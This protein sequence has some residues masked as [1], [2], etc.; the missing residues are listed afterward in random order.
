MTVRNC[1]DNGLAAGEI[2][3]DEHAGLVQLYEGLL[4]HYGDPNAARAE[5]VNRLMAQHQHAQRQALINQDVLQRI[6]GFM[7]GYRNARGEADPAKAAVSLLNH[8]GRVR[9]PHGMSSVVGRYKSIV[10]LM[11]A[12][13]EALVDE[14]R[15]EW[16]TGRTGS[17]ARLENVVREAAG[18]GTGD[19]AAAFL[20][21]AWLR[22]AEQ[23][24]QRYNAAGGAI[25]ELQGWFLPQVHD[26]LSLLRAGMDQW[27]ADITP[28]IDLARMRHPLTGQPMTQADLRTSL[29]WVYRNITTDGWAEREPSAARR[30]LGAIANQ[31]QEH[32]FLHFRSADDW[33]DYH[34]QYGGG[35]DPWAAMMSHVKGMAEDIAAM[36]V[37]GTNP[38]ATIE[39]VEQF[40][41]RQ[42]ALRRA[43]QQAVFPTRS[44]YLGIAYEPDRGWLGARNPEDYAR[45]QMRR[46]R[47]MWDIYR[48]A[49]NAAVNQSVADAF[50]AMRNWNTATKLGGATLSALS[51]NAFQIV[52]R[53]FNG[54][55]AARAIPEIVGAFSRGTQ[56][57]AI[58]G[59]IILDT[60]TNMLRRDASWATTMQGPGWSRLLADRVIAYSG[61]QAVTQAGKHMFG[62]SWQ[63]EL[64]SRVAQTFAELPG[65]LRRA[66]EHYGLSSADWDAMRGSMA[67]N[68]FLRPPDVARAMQAAGRDGERI[69]E[70]YLEMILQ[71]TAYSTPEATL[72]ISA[73][74]YGGLR[75]GTFRDE[76]YRSIS[77][78]KMFGLTVAMLHSQ[79][80]A[81]QM[82]EEG[83]I[84]GAGYAASLLILTGVLGAMSLQLKRVA[85]GKD[86]RPMDVNM[87]ADSAK[88]WAAALLQGGGL[89]IYG[90]LLAA[91]QSRLGGGLART[92]AGPTL[93]TAASVLSLSS[94]NVGQLI[95]GDKTNVG[96]ELTRFVSGNTP[97]GTLWYVRAAY[98]HTLIDRL[99]RLAD[100]EAAAAFQRRMET[101]RRDY[102]SGFWWRPGDRLPD[103]APE[104]GL[105]LG[106]R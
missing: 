56:R 104:W 57:E 72:E 97:G 64:G 61:L 85:A 16:V 70:R 23:L 14:F 77:Q 65:P 54:L 31:R 34:R 4:Q 69:A 47:D 75:R 3:R 79:R 46:M 81:T 76:I 80:M 9:M 38:P 43:G 41:T 71:E 83:S 93:D 102:K 24:R 73:M 25:A 89:G 12:E 19:H 92:L 44:E 82:I 105:A 88:F 30:G 74:A 96:R 68:H 95:R 36:E 40:V 5:M 86:P 59:G 78:F 101:E 52:T 55:P 22:V 21:D 100:P 66:F 45:A 11:G 87:S 13:L 103:R 42:A 37:L 20:A 29:E 35:A 6:E 15:R 51:D 94:G 7:L 49:A 58:A 50:D 99:Q 10:G 1:L 32:R 2:S 39:Y 33:M 27:V 60:A 28:R 91:E 84:R 8:N 67:H 106:R 18:Q 26:R 63:A 62:L 48:G 53:S 90:D 98:E 17:T